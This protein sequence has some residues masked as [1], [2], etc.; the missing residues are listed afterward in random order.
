MR[1]FFNP[2]IFL[3]EIIAFAIQAVVAYGFLIIVCIG[4]IWY[5]ISTMPKETIIE[6]E[7]V[8]TET[9]IINNVPVNSTRGWNERICKRIEGCEVNF[10]ATTPEEYCPTCVW[11]RDWNWHKKSKNTGIVGSSEPDPDPKTW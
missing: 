7:V 2:L 6:R 4:I 11:S 8:H 10:G 3:F 5:G 9:K 1:F